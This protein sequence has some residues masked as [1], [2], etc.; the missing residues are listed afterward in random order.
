[1][2]TPQP[3]VHTYG[4]ITHVY[5]F[6]PSDDRTV[7]HYTGEEVAVVH[8]WIQRQSGDRLDVEWKGVPR[9]SSGEWGRALRTGGI[10]RGESTPEWMRPLI[11]AVPQP[12]V[13]WEGQDR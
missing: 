9:N 11:D 5:R 10:W 1:M 13:T 8:L 7:R 3:T 2:T 6:E 4:A 12:V